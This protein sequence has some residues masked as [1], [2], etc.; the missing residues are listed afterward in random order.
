MSLF[1][2]GVTAPIHS[3]QFHLTLAYQFDEEKQKIL[4]S[5][6][7]E[8]SLDLPS[9]WELQLYSRNKKT[10]SAKQVFVTIVLFL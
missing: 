1:I 8:I 4:D 2:E 9:D 3:G 10:A 6:V 7:K 5:L